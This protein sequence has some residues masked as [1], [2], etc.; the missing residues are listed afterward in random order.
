MLFQHGATGGNWG[1][2]FSPGDQMDFSEFGDNDLA[3]GA[4]PTDTATWH[5]VAWVKDGDS[6]TN[7]T[8]YVDGVVVGTVTAGAT[9]AGGAKRLGGDAWYD[10]DYFDGLLDN[11]RLYDRALTPGEI[12]TDL[13]AAVSAPDTTAP[14]ITLTAPLSGWAKRVYCVAG[15]TTVSSPKP[16]MGWPKPLVLVFTAWWLSVMS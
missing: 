9:T 5:H 10:G 3:S 1:V 14:S 11:V 16:Q 4:A 8:F 15:R 13:A 2:Y 7:V 6:G 12:Q